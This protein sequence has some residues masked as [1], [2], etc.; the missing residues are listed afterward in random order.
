MRAVP[1]GAEGS[2]YAW[3]CSGVSLFFFVS[4]V[5]ASVGL[6]ELTC[7]LGMWF[8]AGSRGMRLALKRHEGPWIFLSGMSPITQA[9]GISYE[10]SIRA[11]IVINEKAMCTYRQLSTSCAAERQPHNLWRLI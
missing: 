6:G 5:A 2:V 9:D 1:G 7:G 3:L 8:M 11:F 4:T 10:D